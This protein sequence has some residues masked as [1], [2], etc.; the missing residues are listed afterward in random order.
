MPQATLV[1][2]LEVKTGRGTQFDNRRQVER[3]YQAIFDLRER[4]HCAACNRRYLILFTF[5]FRPIFQ[6]DE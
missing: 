4:A 2:Q 3:E 5:T 6:A 1:N